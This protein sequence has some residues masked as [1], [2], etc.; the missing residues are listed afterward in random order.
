M[1]GQLRDSAGRLNLAE[2]GRRMSRAPQGHGTRQPRRWIALDRNGAEVQRG[3]VMNGTDANGAPF[4]AEF[5]HAAGR[6]RVIMDGHTYPASI[7]D[8]T[9][10]T[11]QAERNN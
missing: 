5:W 2:A 10:V 1:A 6:D 9:T 3:T 7:W 4:Q 11:V 8:L